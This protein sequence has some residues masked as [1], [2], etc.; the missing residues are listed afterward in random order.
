MQTEVQCSVNT[1]RQQT[2]KPEFAPPFPPLVLV[3]K[4]NLTTAE[5]AYYLNRKPQTLR[6]WAC[7]EDGPIRP[8]RIFGLLAWPTDAVKALLGVA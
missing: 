7:Y 8:T 3:N 4:P 2:A 1:L 6:T 5:L